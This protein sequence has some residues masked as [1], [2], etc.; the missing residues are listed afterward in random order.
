MNGE[1]IFCLIQPHSSTADTNVSYSIDTRSQKGL[2]MIK[3]KSATSLIESMQAHA[4][5]NSPFSLN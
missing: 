5:V 3:S 2:A 4:F 1:L